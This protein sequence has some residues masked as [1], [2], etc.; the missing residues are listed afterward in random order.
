MTRAAA[1]P[2]GWGRARFHR[3]KGLWPLNHSR[4]AIQDVVASCNIRQSNP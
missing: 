2:R 4:G 1:M 3:P